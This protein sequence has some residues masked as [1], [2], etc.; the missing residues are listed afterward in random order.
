MKR[1]TRILFT[2]ASIGFSL[3]IVGFLGL[4]AVFQ[5]FAHDLP[6]YGRLAGYQPAT[7][8][9]VYSNDGQLIAEYA[10]EK[11][12]YQPLD[13]IP[14]RVIQGFLAAEDQNFYRH[15]G[16]DAKS[17]IRAALENLQNLGADN[18]N[19]VGGSTITQQVV[20]NFLLTRERT[21]SRK[22]KEAI[23]ASR[24][25]KAYSKDRILE[26]YLNE[27]YL[28]LGAYGIT[29]ASQI[30][31]GK[32]PDELS[33]EEIALLAAMPKGP[34]GLDPRRYPEKALRRRNEYVLQRMFEDGYINEAE[35]ERAA[36]T[37]ITLYDP[38][39][40]NVTQAPY[41]AEEVRKELVE[42]YGEETLNAGGL[43]V[44]TTLIP[45]LQE[46]ADSSLRRALIEYD[47]RHGYRGP[48]AHLETMENWAVPLE[49]IAANTPVYKG[50]RVG[51]VREMD[52]KTAKL[53]FPDADV[54][55]LAV[56]DMKWARL[57]GPGGRW[58]PVPAK[59]ADTLKIGDV[60]LV[61]SIEEKENT[62][63]LL[64]IP[65]VN[66]GLIMLDPHT[67]RV[68]AM[69]GGY[70]A[71][72]QFNRVTQA[73]RQPGSAFKPFVYLTAMEHGFTPATIV[74]DEPVEIYQ[75]PGLPLWR[76]KNYGGEYLGPATLR[77]GLEKSRNVMT[78]RLA[79]M[80]GIQRVARAAKRFGIYDD[81]PANYSMVL[82]ALE[83]TMLKLANAYG[84]IANGGLKISPSF[85]E[86]ID[87]RNGV[88]LYRRDTRP[89]TGCVLDEERNSVNY[90]TPVPEDNRERIVDPRIAYQVTSLLQ[91]V[92]QRGTAASAAKLG[93]P[94]AG[95]T[96]TTNDSRDA[97]FMGFSPDLVVGVYVGFDQPKNLG[98]KETGGRVALPAFIQV[99]EQF[100]KHYQVRDF[101]V[102]MGV[103]I[104][105][106]D[107]YT[108]MSPAPWDTQAKV[109]S[110]AF[111]YGGSVFI[112]NEE[113][114]EEGIVPEYADGIEQPPAGYQPG[115]G[116]EG[117]LPPWQTGQEQH[118]AT[119]GVPVP[120]GV[121]DAYSSP[122]NAS[123]TLN[124]N[125]E[126]LI[127]R[128][129]RTIYPSDKQRPS[130]YGRPQQQRRVPDGN[131][132]PDA[133]LPPR[134]VGT[135]GIY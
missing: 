43:F 41:F 123:P 29:A 120:D 75:G 23:L 129:G 35:M 121:P 116:W 84:I 124:P 77:V 32:S 90:V 131:L 94:L 48:L 37:P 78:V 68:L 104:V 54:G 31:F 52:A 91:G 61:E 79:Q 132:P 133:V 47:R 125:Q 4:L 57:I 96:G 26:L 1:V 92:V 27:I 59:P 80:L 71:Q 95:K 53:G 114:D 58:G 105:P 100:S 46:L 107:R 112:P 15:G 60:V 51:V 108:G 81:P 9:R 101:D 115:G 98:G 65:A 102:P 72:T 24:I 45:E 34:S 73:L 30:Y 50:Q 70:S 113:R 128:S 86:R 67:G 33:T 106:V 44:R 117:G 6:D 55:V 36:A 134:V 7:T 99:M 130:R 74:V 42:K 38:A 109:I 76:P 39:G 11:R 69:A 87:D 20:K 56:A 18:A 17:I 40:E 66:G 135:G 111:I 63:R 83:T 89:C 97:W 13:R 5:Y 2:L 82:G 14:R 22:I 3:G 8:T 28:G 126:H 19:L 127:P 118:P 12:I 10:E 103:Q 122:W 16:I 25:T 62:Y 64:Q 85:I 21:F 49:K 88:T 93:L 119:D 110:E